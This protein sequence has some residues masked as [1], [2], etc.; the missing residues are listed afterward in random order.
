MLLEKKGDYLVQLKK[1]T[2]LVD[3]RNILLRGYSMTLLEGKS[4][5]SIKNIKPG[6]LLETRLYEGSIISKVEH[7][8]KKNDKRED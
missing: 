4:I 7:T 8:S 2:E 3:P 1:R 5:S 6:S